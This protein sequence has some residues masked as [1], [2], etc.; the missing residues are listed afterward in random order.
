MPSTVIVVCPGRA[1]TKA[2]CHRA[3]QTKFPLPSR[4][5]STLRHWEVADYPEVADSVD[6]RACPQK[7]ADIDGLRS[8]PDDPHYGLGP[9]HTSLYVRVT[10]DWWLGHLQGERHHF[11]CHF[12]SQFCAKLDTK[13]KQSLKSDKDS[14]WSSGICAP[15]RTPFRPKNRKKSKKLRSDN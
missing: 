15:P 8:P 14:G 3:P 12:F 11:F 4:P 1:A 9:V 10:W 6:A 2:L 7:T 5:G 13:K